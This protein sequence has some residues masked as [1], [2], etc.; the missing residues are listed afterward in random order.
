MSS[1]ATTKASI[2]E[3]FHSKR[4]I[5]AVVES[6][7]QP[8]GRGDRSGSPSAFHPKLPLAAVQFQ[9]HWRLIQ[10]GLG[11]VARL[12]IPSHPERVISSAS[13][14]QCGRE[15]WQFV[16]L[17][18]GILLL[19][20]GACGRPEFQIKQAWLR[21]FR[22]S[23]LVLCAFAPGGFDRRLGAFTNLPLVSRQG[24]A[25]AEAEPAIKLIAVSPMMS[26]AFPLSSSGCSLVIRS[27][28][29]VRVNL[30]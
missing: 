17:D 12:E 11:V 28:A 4:L 10:V 5:Y 2:G 14:T 18:A 22:T 6:L 7:R 24:A 13:T 8:Y 27:L 20:G 3:A 30:S 16:I 15:F 9:T 25:R 29:D 21:A 26:C 19:F 23:R 1:A